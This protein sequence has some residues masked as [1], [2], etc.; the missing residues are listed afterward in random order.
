MA[1]VVLAFA[2]AGSFAQPLNTQIYL[3]NYKI[4]KEGKY[5]FTDPVKI[6]GDAAYNNQ[7]YFTQDGVKILFSKNPD[8]VQTDI[9][10][11][12]IPDS[13]ALQ[14]STSHES[15][16]SPQLTPDG[17]AISVIRVDDDK[18]QRFYSVTM[19]GEDKELIL[20]PCDS[21][22]YY[23]WVNKTT[24]AMLVLNGKTMDLVLYDVPSLSYVPLNKGTGRCIQNIP[25]SE[26]FS[27]VVK[28]DTAHSY[29]L[30]YSIVD[31]MS[32]TLCLLPKG[33]EDYA[34]GGPENFLRQQWKNC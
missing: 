18:A 15:D 5:I 33:V 34:W 12:I 26:D 7:P 31:Q 17:D 13:N 6:T 32:D 23:C 25:E 9:Y 1:A 29:L 20:P 3:T 10:Q 27:F 2:F 22:A 8:S 11:Y 30:R 19:N 24:V 16:Y 21:A 14:I 28:P 4:S